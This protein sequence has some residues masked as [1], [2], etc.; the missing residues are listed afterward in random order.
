M[1]RDSEA[2]GS[3]LRDAVVTASSS[4]GMNLLWLRPGDV[5]GTETY[6]RRVI[7]A[8]ITQGSVGDLHLFGTEPAIDAVR[9][10]TGAIVPH[11]AAPGPIP[12][13]RRVLLE[14][15]WLRSATRSVDLDVLHHLGGTVPFDSDIPLIVTIHDLQPLDEPENFAPVKVRFLRTA[16]PAAIARASLITTPSDWVRSRVIARFDIDPRRVETVSAYAEPVDLSAVAT[17]S[18]RIEAL[19]ANGPILLFPAM[20]LAHKNHRFLFNAFGDALRRDP[21]LQLVCVGAV[22]R[23]HDELVADAAAVS[24]RI[25]MLGHVSKEDLDA[26]YRIADVVVFPSRY[27]GFGLPVLEAQN[28]GVPLICSNTTALP[29]VA[30]MGALFLDPTDRASWAD[31]MVER[32]GPNERGPI[33]ARGFANA[34]R[35]SIDATADQQQRAYARASA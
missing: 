35:Y 18:P 10:A 2:N 29:E 8:L 16:I 28:Y 27:E 32:F 19:G 31:A 21:D 34:Q 33:V 26:L 4:I 30:G 11:S 20:T 3:D 1:G 24:P 23:D 5:G 12:P 14:R 6:A 13:A 22:G 17:P 7:R 9:P 25:R 15:T